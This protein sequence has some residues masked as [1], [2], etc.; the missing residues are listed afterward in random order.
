MAEK[1]DLVPRAV[2][3]KFEPYTPGRSMD[4]VKKEYGLK[5]AVKLASNENPL[6]PSPRAVAA[7]KKAAARSHHYPDAFSTDLRKALSAHARVPVPNI[8]LGAGSDELIELLGRAYLT[9]AD[10]IVAS[11]H[12]FIRY[13]MA[14]DIMEA[15]TIEVPMGGDLKHDLTAMARAVTPRTKLVFVANPNNPTGTYNGNAEMKMFLDALP[16]HVLPVLDEAYYEYAKALRPDYADGLSFFKKGRRL[17]VLRTFSKIHGLAGLRLGWGV[18]P[19]DVVE[20]LERI[21]PPF[22]I[23][24]PAQA[25]G[26]AAIADERQVARSVRLV[27]VEMGKMGRAL[28]A[29]GVSWTPSAGNFLMVSVAPRKGR[30]VFEGL[31]RRGVIVRALDEYAL[32]GH[33]RVTIGLS[34]ENKMFLKAFDEVTGGEKS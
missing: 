9:S 10:N 32:P 14:A 28:T 17:M 20:S 23:N 19:E 18:G 16:D 15:G 33:I 24:L 34:A 6:G 25:A 12:A 31:L 26:A 21:R 3:G 4:Q 8:A 2:V 7:A 11:R 1:K 13:R 22:N 29:R 5:R 30:D 27:S